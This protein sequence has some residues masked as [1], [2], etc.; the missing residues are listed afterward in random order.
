MT[1]AT[2][3]KRLR[4]EVLIHAVPSSTLFG[5]QSSR[6]TSSHLD[7]SVSYDNPEP[8]PEL[9]QAGLLPQNQPFYRFVQASPGKVR[10]SPKSSTSAS[11]RLRV[12]FS[13]LSS[14]LHRKPSLNVILSGA[15]QGCH[16]AARMI[17]NPPPLQ[18]R[19][20]RPKIA[21]P[22]MGGKGA[23]GAKFS[24]VRDGRHSARGSRT[25]SW[26]FSS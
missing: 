20:G 17:T 12:R 8:A 14:P 21:H 25:W 15:D 18:S 5:P 19:Q 11:L 4:V 3:P 16:G 6:E 22:F 9:R 13:L 1:S 23:S 2:A 24:P 7:R 26:C 10:V